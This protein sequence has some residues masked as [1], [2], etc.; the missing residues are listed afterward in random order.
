MRRASLRDIGVAIAERPVP[1]SREL[2]GGPP[3]AIPDG[4]NR[5]VL[6][7]ALVFA[8]CGDGGDPAPDEPRW[9]VTYSGTRSLTYSTPCPRFSFGDNVSWTSLPHAWADLSGEFDLSFDVLETWSSPDGS[10][11]PT[12]HYTLDAFGDT[13]VGLATTSFSFDTETTGTTCEYVWDVHAVAGDATD[14]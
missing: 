11:S 6:V 2:A 9:A 5:R 8:G 13:L 10:A 12:I 4:V 7:L 14:D 1:R 3:V